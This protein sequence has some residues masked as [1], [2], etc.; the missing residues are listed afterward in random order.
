MSN[1]MAF[2]IRQNLLPVF[3]EEKMGYYDVDHPLILKRA[4]WKENTSAYVR[5]FVRVECPDWTMDSFKYDESNTLPAWAENQDEEIRYRVGRT[6][7][8]I[9]AA[10]SE[11]LEACKGNPS[12]ATKIKA[13]DKELA[14]YRLIPGYLSPPSP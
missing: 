3:I 9:N 13:Y 4:G 12:M 14:A 5:F 7:K 6:L 1:G 8:K 11:Y 10:H 2:L